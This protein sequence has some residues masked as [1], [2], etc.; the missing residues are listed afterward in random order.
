MNKDSFEKLNEYQS[1]A[2]DYLVPEQLFE[3]D[4]D[5]GMLGKILDRGLS[6]V[7]RAMR[8]KKAKKIMGKSLAGFSSKA[9]ALVT[10]FS[11][12]FKSKV[13]TIDKEYTKLIKDKVKPLIEEGKTK[14][15]VELLEGQK[16]ELEDY[17]KEQM[18]ILDK[19]IEDILGAYTN[20]INH[21]IDNPGFVLNVELSEKGKGELKAKWEELAATQKIEIDKDKTKL[22]SSQGWRRLGEMVAEMNGL[23]KNKKGV[24]ADVDI[25]IQ[26]NVKLNEETY[27]VK[28]HIRV[29]GGRPTLQEKGLLIG[30]DPEKLDYTAGVRTIKVTGTYQYNTRPFDLQ[31]NA[32]KTEF[33]RPYLIF[34]DAPQPYYGDIG[35]FSQARDKSDSTK[36]TG[37]DRIK[38]T[39]KPGGSLSGEDPII[40]KENK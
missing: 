32:K 26:D 17:K 25:F 28:V 37:D 2:S 4:D 6:F 30:S 15:A 40:K 38:G 36:K 24:E 29:Q 7:P 18:S 21:R 39:G 35:A 11:A 20:S 22:I 5:D 3:K 16:K 9:K 13:A 1:E 33:V 23:I 14:E 27:Q 19:G 10:K 8:F 31:V 12:G 34:K